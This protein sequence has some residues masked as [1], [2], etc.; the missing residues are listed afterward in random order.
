MQKECVICGHPY[1]EEHHIIYRGQQAALIS[2]PHNKLYLCY[3]HHR[4]N[5]SPHM[6]RRIDLKY[7][8]QLQLKLESLFNH[9]ECYSEEEVKRILL[10]PKKDVRKLLKPLT[11]TS[12]GGEVGYHRN[13]VIRQALGGRN[14]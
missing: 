12:F 11:L 4:G 8:R 13:D 10:I 7:K 9:K 2:C 14:Y 6:D 3:E 5:K 1:P